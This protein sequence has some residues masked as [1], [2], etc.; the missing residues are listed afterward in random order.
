MYQ[1]SHRPDRFRGNWLDRR[2]YNKP[3]L[4]VPDWGWGQAL[5]F[6]TGPVPTTASVQICSDLMACNIYVALK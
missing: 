3:L 6:T 1:D 5:P 4:R 2:I